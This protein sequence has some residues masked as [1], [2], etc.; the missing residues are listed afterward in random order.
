MTRR[1]PASAALAAG[2]HGDLS[3]NEPAAKFSGHS[4]RAAGPLGRG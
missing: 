4:L 2:L 1:S 3:E